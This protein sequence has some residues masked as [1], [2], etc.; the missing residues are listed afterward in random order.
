MRV[1]SRTLMLSIWSPTHRTK[2]QTF[3][4]TDY[5]LNSLNLF[6]RE[7]LPLWDLVRS[8]LL[9]VSF[10]NSMMMVFHICYIIVIECTHAAASIFRPNQ[11]EK[12]IICEDL[13][14]P[15][16]RLSLWWILGE[17]I[18]TGGKPTHPRKIQITFP[19]LYLGVVLP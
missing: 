18:K 7:R 15:V 16:S 19:Y 3:N 14:K 8:N 5:Y 1:K 6:C 4:H 12:Q 13:C 2:L 17:D 9:Q 11:R 10:Y